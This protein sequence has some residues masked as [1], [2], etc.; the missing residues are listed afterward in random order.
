MLW[1]VQVILQIEQ[2]LES[3]LNAQQ[4]WL[5][6]QCFLSL[7]FTWQIKSPGHQGAHAW[8]TSITLL[9]VGIE[10]NRKKQASQVTLTSN[11]GW[12]WRGFCVETWATSKESWD[13]KHRRSVSALHWCSFQGSYET[14]LFPLSVESEC[15]SGG[16]MRLLK[17]TQLLCK[18][19]YTEHK[20]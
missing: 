4:Q 1:E 16:L 19:D 8:L 11:S 18:W 14:V 13:L 10:N 20:A 5:Q 17:I 7:K 15:G 3:D 2:S 12:K 9:T 6:I